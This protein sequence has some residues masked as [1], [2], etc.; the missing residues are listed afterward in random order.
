MSPASYP[1][2]AS[3]RAQSPLLGGGSRVWTGTPQPKGA[4]PCLPVGCSPGGGRLGRRLTSPPTQPE[5]L[6]SSTGH[7]EPRRRP[8]PAACPPP[9]LPQGPAA[10]SLPSPSH[11]AWL[12]ALAS[13]RSAVAGAHCSPRRRD[14]PAWAGASDS[15]PRGVAQG[16]RF[17]SH[18]LRPAPAEGTEAL[19][20]EH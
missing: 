1:E 7:R 17:P 4:R 15:A 10:Q 18:G 14:R 9:R 8:G 2:G 3:L 12:G 13:A 19:V 6:A 16:C 20:G 11:V 5:M